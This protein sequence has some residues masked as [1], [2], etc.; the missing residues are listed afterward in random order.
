[1][2]IDQHRISQIVTKSEYFQD[3]LDKAPS[4]VVTKANT[5]LLVI[6][7]AIAMGSC[8][9]K[10]PD[11]IKAE[12]L[13]T[14]EKPPV[15]V[16]SRTSGLITRFSKKDQNYVKKGE[17]I[18]VLNNS[19]EYEEILSTKLLIESLNGKNFWTA[20]ENADFK[21]YNSLGNIQNSYSQFIRSVGELR[22]FSE[23]N[24]QFK[25][26][27]IN[28]RRLDNLNALKAQ[29][30]NQI[31]IQERQVAIA[32]TD[33]DR[34]KKLE[35]ET[36]VPKVEVEQKEIVFLNANNRC[37]ELKGTLI[38]TQ[39]QQEM[40][41][42]EN[43]SLNNEKGDTYF[44]LRSNVLQQYNSLAYELKEWEN[45]YVISAPIDGIINLYDVRSEEQF[46]A[47]EQKV[48]TI[49]PKDAK[50]FF[51]ILKLPI[52]NSGKVKVGQQC[53]IKLHNFPPAEFGVL[54]GT[55]S[56]ISQTA[57]EGFFSIR[58][59]LNDQLR[60]TTNVNLNGKSELIGDAEI[61]VKNEALFDK[62]FNTLFKKY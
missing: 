18:I 55:V 46:L 43:I 13:I 44:R 2:P 24:L 32:K 62:I 5:I 59:I 61:I 14:S 9:V 50:D 52:S 16:F 57:N 6:F 58:V 31:S 45:R 1:M 47:A 3:I 35:S 34:I 36:V 51:S 15:Q 48:F 39:L 21:E 38:S 41:A 23:I 49:T 10:Y 37:E 56:S 19:A 33:L 25:Q 54:K 60:T 4:S 7:I 26:L 30:L 28:I 40:V 8:F 12:A 53:V 20:L 27:T 17:W 22:L 29:L 42:K 11:V